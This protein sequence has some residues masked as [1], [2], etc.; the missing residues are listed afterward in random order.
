[1]LG[2]SAPSL[3]EEPTTSPTM[4]RLSRQLLLKMASEMKWPIGSGDVKTAFLQARP[5]ERSRRLLAKPLPELAEAIGLGP[6]QAV[7]LTGSAYGL[8]QAPR[9][10]FLDIQKTSERLGARPCRTDPCLWRIFGSNGRVCGLI[11]AYVD[12]SCSQGTRV[13]QHGLAS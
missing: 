11:G 4:S 5:E 2:Y 12:D 7:E 6:K 10:W 9:E 3:L 1:M 8:A 13:H